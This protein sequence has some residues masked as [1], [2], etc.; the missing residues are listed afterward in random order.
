MRSNESKSVSLSEAE[1][2]FNESVQCSCLEF[3]EVDESFDDG[4]IETDNKLFQ[5]S[6]CQ[7]KQ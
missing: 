1:A 2:Q 3:D 5:C 4:L 7:P 6:G